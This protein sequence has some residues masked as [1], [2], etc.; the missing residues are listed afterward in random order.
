MN[1]RPR[2]LRGM[3]YLKQQ[4][5]SVRL[6]ERSMG[7]PVICSARQLFLPALPFSSLPFASPSL[8]FFCLFGC[9]VVEVSDSLSFL[10]PLYCSFL[11]FSSLPRH[12]PSP[13]LSLFCLFDCHAVV[14]SGIRFGIYKRSSRLC[15]CRAPPP[16]PPPHFQCCPHA[17]VA[18]YENERFLFPRKSP[19]TDHNI[20][21]WGS[22]GEGDR[23]SRM[24]R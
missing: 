14:V 7:D 17:S 9:H 8:S 22:R 1:H 5:I 15:G 16:R 11:L 12:L 6:C 3:P 10:S 24:A 13:S 21:F 2:T 23:I 18:D 19:P 20:E 4:K